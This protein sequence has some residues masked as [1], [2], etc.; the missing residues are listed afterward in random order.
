[1]AKIKRGDFKGLNLTEMKIAL[2]GEVALAEQ[3]IRDAKELGQK[4]GLDALYAKAS[5]MKNLQNKVNEA[6]KQATESMSTVTDK[7]GA[8]LKARDEL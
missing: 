7:C 5:E 4:D 2:L 6:V 8:R 3:A 1:M